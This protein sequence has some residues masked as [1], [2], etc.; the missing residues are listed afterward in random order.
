[1]L[2]HGNKLQQR[3]G[4]KIPQ[5]TMLKHT[6]PTSARPSETRPPTGSITCNGCFQYIPSPHATALNRVPAP[7]Y[8]SP[9]HILSVPAALHKTGLSSHQLTEH[10]RPLRC[11][12]CCRFASCTRGIAACA[13]QQV[14]CCHSQH[15][16]LLSAQSATRLQPGHNCCSCTCSPPHPSPLQHSNPAYTAAAQLAPLHHAA[17]C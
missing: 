2:V 6:I 3:D 7:A 10:A 14:H 11:C 1:M 8:H 12:R 4:P 17:A 15:S 9:C 16:V 5:H 13:R